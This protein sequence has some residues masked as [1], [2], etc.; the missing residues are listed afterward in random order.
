VNVLKKI[1]HFFGRRASQCPA[2]ERPAIYALGLWE[3]EPDLEKD[4]SAGA[5]IDDIA[6]GSG[7]TAVPSRS[8][9]KLKNL[10]Q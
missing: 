4:I 2:P 6:W 10:F 8:E 9:S 1:Q 7:Q 3:S 5:F